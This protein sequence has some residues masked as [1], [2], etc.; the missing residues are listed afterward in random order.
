ME[1]IIKPQLDD[2]QPANHEEYEIVDRVNKEAPFL[3]DVYNRFKKKKRGSQV[4]NRI[5]IFIIL[6]RYL[7]LL[8]LRE[9]MMIR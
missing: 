5:I 1:K 6:W 2:F 7:Y 4:V 8:Y 9:N 3:V